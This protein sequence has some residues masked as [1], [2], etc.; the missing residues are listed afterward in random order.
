[1]LPKA[2]SES[3]NYLLQEGLL[4]WGSYSSEKTVGF[5]GLRPLRCMSKMAIKMKK[6]R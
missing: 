4:V 2:S 5:F 3:E 1:M 6:M